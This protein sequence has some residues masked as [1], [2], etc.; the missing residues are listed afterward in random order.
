LNERVEYEPLELVDLQM[1]NKKRIQIHPLI[2]YHEEIGFSIG[3]LI[4]SVPEVAKKSLLFLADSVF[5]ADFGSLEIPETL[6]NSIQLKELSWLDIRP[7]WS[8][9]LLL[10]SRELIK[11]NKNVFPSKKEVFQKA[12]QGLSQYWWHSDNRYLTLVTCWIIGT[13]FHPIFSFYPAL[14]VQGQRETGKST[15]LEILS[16]TCWNSTGRETAIR[17]ADIFRTVEG[18]RGTYIIDVTKFDLGNDD[19]KDVVD[20]IEVGTEKGGRVRRIDKESMKPQEFEVYSPKAIATRYELPFTVKCIRI[21]TEKA[22]KEYSQRR[23]L[24]PFDNRFEEVV[25]LLLRAAVKYWR[26]IVEAYKSIPQ[27]EKLTG[28]AFNYWAPLLAVCKVFAPDRYEELLGLAEE[29][30]EKQERGDRLSEVEDGIL[31]VLSEFEGETATIL[32]KDLTEKVTAVIPWIKTWHIVKGALQNLGVTLRRYET[33]Q[34]VTYQLDLKKA[35]EKAVQR[36]IG[37]LNENSLSVADILSQLRTAFKKGTEDEFKAL[38]VEKGLSEADVDALFNRLVDEG[39]LAMDP[40]GFW[41][42]A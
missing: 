26:D 37:P 12:F 10:L 15:L 38:A 5:I 7:E 2:D 20:L 31:A 11:G 34:G 28:R 39:S 22:P 19:T 13:Y 16:R 33:S 41:R 1:E 8:Y 4:D 23:A 21:F 30:A 3:T 24:L 40:D 6:H 17:G 35:R 36:G 9:A 32:L 18:T 29:M 25:G 42:W 27:T 14:N